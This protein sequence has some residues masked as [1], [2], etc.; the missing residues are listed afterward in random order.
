MSKVGEGR[1]SDLIKRF[2]SLALDS[3]SSGTPIRMPKR[4]SA[5]P[6]TTTTEGVPRSKLPS[7]AQPPHIST[8]VSTAPPAKE[9]QG[10]VASPPAHVPNSADSASSSVQDLMTISSY[11]YS[12]TTPASASSPRQP[13]RMQSLLPGRSRANTTE[14]VVR[15]SQTEAPKQRMP[16]NSSANRQ[17]TLVTAL[18][19]RAN[20]DPAIQASSR[21]WLNSA[22]RR[23]DEAL[24]DLD[25]G[26]LE[27]AYLRFMI[28][29]NI[30]SDKVPKQKDFDSVKKDPKYIKLHKDMSAR[31]LDELEKLSVELRRRPY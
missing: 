9:G 6:V 26:D 4:S 5:L 3:N 22:E 29:C 10:P 14:S 16:S 19:Q 31:I 20:I 27:N 2:E 23:I 7:D 28:A 21:S 15:L 17:K 18:N 8:A 13:E 1:T 30:I 12:H 11:S 24:L 25:S